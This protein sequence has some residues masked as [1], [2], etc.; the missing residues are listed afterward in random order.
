LRVTDLV[1]GNVTRRRAR[2]DVRR[3]DDTLMRALFPGTLC[4]G[5]PVI[6]KLLTQGPVVV[7]IITGRK[8][9]ALFSL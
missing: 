9:L 1:F 3:S 8:D 4:A 7:F 5:L 2:T 6:G